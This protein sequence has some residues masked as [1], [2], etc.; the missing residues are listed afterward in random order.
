MKPATKKLLHELV[1]ALEA[2]GMH[3]DATDVE[4]LT[5]Q[6]GSPVLEERQVAAEQIARRCHVK[7]FGD[8]NLPVS[9]REPYGVWKFLDEVRSAVR[10][11]VG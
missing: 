1:D 4:Q 2:L 6:L 8:L 3:E 10:A 7:W 5:Q 9:R 11:E